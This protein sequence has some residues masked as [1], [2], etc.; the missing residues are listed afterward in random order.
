MKA[1]AAIVLPFI[2]L[3]NAA[4]ILPR[5]GYRGCRDPSDYCAI[6]NGIADCPICEYIVAIGFISLLLLRIPHR[7]TTAYSEVD[8]DWDCLIIQLGF[9]VPAGC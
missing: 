2:A 5:Q 6:T 4:A 8:V 9:A 7:L 3:A 1:F